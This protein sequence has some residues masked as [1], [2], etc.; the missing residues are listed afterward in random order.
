MSEGT[1]K[2]GRILV[3]EDDAELLGLLSEQLGHAGYEVTAVAT[4]GEG[5]Y[6]A[7]ERAFDLIV[8]DLNLPD[9]DGIEVAEALSGQVDTPILMLTSRGDVDSR[10][11]GLYAGASDYVTKP[12]AVPELVARVHARLRE[13]GR[14]D[15]RVRHGGLELDT[16]TLRVKGAGGEVTLPEREFALLRTLLENPGRVFGRFELERRIYEGELPESNTVE[17]FVHNLRRKLSELGHEGVIRTVRGKGYLV[18]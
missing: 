15:G 5:L 7:E 8:L 14:G 4:G 11:E 2:R 12:F 9:V 13:R 17:V 18:R 1:G 10:V 6:Q 3:V 16:E